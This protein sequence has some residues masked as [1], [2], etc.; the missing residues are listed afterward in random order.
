MSIIVLA[1]FS[2]HVSL[3][4]NTVK[5]ISKASN[6][7]NTTSHIFGFLHM[8]PH[9]LNLSKSPVNATIRLDPEFFG[10]LEIPTLK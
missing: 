8:D 2:N 9:L 7:T 4:E 5:N 3:A 1:T 6:Y 10:T